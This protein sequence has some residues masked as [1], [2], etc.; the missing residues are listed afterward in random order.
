V[1]GFNNPLVCGIMD[2]SFATCFGFTEE[3]VK[4]A[5]EMY[6]L[7][8]QFNEVKKWYDGYRFGG[9]DMYNPWSII[10]YLK[11]KEIDNYWVNTGSV[12][13]LQDVF[14]KGD[15]AIKNELAGLLTGTPVMMRLEDGITYPIK[16]VH[17]NTFWTML[18][19]AGYLKPCNGAYKTEKFGAE[20]VNMEVKNI[21]SRY[22]EEWFG[23]QQPS[24]SRTIVEFVE[25]L[26]QGD[27]EG[28]SAILN[29]EL[30]NNPSCHD[31]KEENS[32]H[33]FIYGILLAV[34]GK[35]TV[36][37]NPESGKG[38]SDC[39]IKPMDKGQYAVVIE[40]KHERE[41]DRDLKQEAQKGLKQIEEKA[42]IH[43]LKKE[44]YERIFKYG[45]AFHK[46]NC[47]VAMGI[48]GS[49]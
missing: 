28:V 36:W 30:L 14:Y 20:L 24:I 26:L 16:Y 48:V 38:R 44:G 39:L 19:N 37:S 13:I 17:S 23:E 49:R 3:E 10:K 4:D 22:A 11:E 46:K 25:Y 32:Y 6:E 5:C 2:K 43:N 21:F 34:S 1:S 35:Y 29:K 41:E 27:A 18:L 31:F 42:Y 8:N 33:M 45:I 15:T 12:H 7:I 9:Q 40:F 47:E